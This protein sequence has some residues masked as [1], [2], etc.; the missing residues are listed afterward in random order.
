MNC[1]I[2]GKPI[3]LIPSAQERS[4]NDLNGN[5]PSYFINLFRIHTECLINKRNGD[6]IELMRRIDNETNT[7]KR[8]N[9]STC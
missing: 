4:K 1:N 6:T 7:K 3:I 9:Y 2:C 5:P 8:R